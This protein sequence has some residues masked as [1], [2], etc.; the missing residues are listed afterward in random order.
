M[1]GG[2]GENWM[3]R[4]GGE[5]RGRGENEIDEGEGV[6]L[7][8]VVARARRAPAGRAQA[9]CAVSSAA[10]ASRSA[11]RA[12]RRGPFPSPSRP[13][14]ALCEA[15]GALSSMCPAHGREGLTPLVDLLGLS[16]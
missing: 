8:V 11:Q 7:L 2:G 4:G 12:F 15:L 13:L 16:S 9:W 14:A 5:D 10:K 1:D 3:E 6:L